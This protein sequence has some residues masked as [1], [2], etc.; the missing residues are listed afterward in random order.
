MEDNQISRNVY[1][2]SVS[3]QIVSDRIQ[4]MFSAIENRISSW[5]LHTVELQC[6]AH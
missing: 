4:G 3:K 1:C 2:E 5:F 6:L